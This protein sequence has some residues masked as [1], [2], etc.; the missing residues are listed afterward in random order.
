MINQKN[1][2]LPLFILVASCLLLFPIFI[3]PSDWAGWLFVYFSFVIPFLF[4]RIRQDRAIVLIFLII[5]AAHNAISI[6]NVYESTV[7]GAGLDAIT[8]Q[9]M[10]RDIA[11]DRHPVWFTNFGTVEIGASIYTR[12]LASFYRIF[13]VSLLLGQSLSVIAYAL[14][15]VVLIYL[16]NLLRFRFKPSILL[17][18]GLP[19][20]AIIYCS[21]I[22]REAWQVLFFMLVVYLT[23]RLRMKPSILTS[24]A[25]LASGLILG[26]L[27]NGL[28]AYA[29]VMLG[30]SIYWGIS[31]KWRAAGIKIIIIRAAILSATLIAFLAWFYLGGEIGGATRAIRAG[32]AVTY[33]ETYR[34]RGEQ[35]AAASYQVRVDVSSPTVFVGTSFLSFIYYQFAP[36]PWQIRRPIDIY[37]GLEAIL[38]FILLIFMSKLWWNAKGERRRRYTYLILCYLSL[39]FLWS[40]GTANWG[41]GVRHHLVAYGVLVLL[42]TP[43]FTY[44]LRRS[45]QR[46]RFRSARRSNRNREKAVRVTGGRKAIGGLP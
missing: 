19:L 15:C 8:F 40:L 9:E 31:G 29:L 16:A 7:Y 38:R 5:I 23:I 42:G 33:T 37:A 44:G 30:L 17:I 46:L 32:E 14:S 3:F 11:T 20:P 28:F 41:T 12:F 27:H 25:M 21:V 39:E 6:Y 1:R 24:L 2:W 13:G 43:G 34:E 22:M 26:F 10:A 36:F 4:A 45:L 18:Y 35:D